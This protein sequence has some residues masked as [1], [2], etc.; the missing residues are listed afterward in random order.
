[1]PQQSMH[2][3]RDTLLTAIAPCVWGSTYL[4]TTEFLP[5]D[6]PLTA[7]V[8]RV[9]PVGI[10]MLAMSRNFPRN[11]V[12]WRLIVLGMLNIGLFQA[13]LFVAAYRLPGG[14]AATVGAIQPLL[15][16]LLTSIVL[17]TRHSKLVWLAALCGMAGVALLVLSPTAALDESGILAALAGTIAMAVGTVLTK[18]W[19]LP[20][21][22]IE[23]TA[24]QL[25]FGGIFLLPLALDLEAIPQHLTL[26]NI[27]GYAY[28]SLIGTGLTYALWFRGVH[29]LSVA[30][31]TLLGLL[32]PLV[33]TLLG[34]LFLRQTL[35]TVQFTGAALIVLSVWAG[36][37]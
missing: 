10:L 27:A 20:L 4:V 5:P 34:Y 23:L 14:V 37:R 25:V 35:N 24:W 3:L 33:A 7:A 36:Q 26:N 9:L 17:S 1:M 13:L 8:I 31:V 30:S 29:R 21:S 18:R 28:L 32:S 12:W 11:D 16:I 6:R 2:T 15:V 19:K 22:T